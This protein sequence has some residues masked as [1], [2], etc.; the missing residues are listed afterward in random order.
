MS[1]YE[2]DSAFCAGLKTDPIGT[3]ES[4]GIEVNEAVFAMLHQI[5]PGMSD[6]QLQQRITKAFRRT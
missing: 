1:R 5:E 2:S 3:V 4:A 6:E